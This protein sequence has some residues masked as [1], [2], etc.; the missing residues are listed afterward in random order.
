MDNDYT[1]VNTDKKIN[2]RPSSIAIGAALAVLIISAIVYFIFFNKGN[3]EVTLPEPVLVEEVIVEET[4]VPAIIE[5]E[6][7]IDEEVVAQD[8]QSVIA[9]MD[10]SIIHLSDYTLVEGEDLNSVALKFD[11]DVQTLLSINK[12]RNTSLVVEGYEIKIPNMDGFIYTVRSGDML[13]TISNKFN[14]DIGWYGLR[15]LNDL[16]SDAIFE[17]Q[18]LFIPTYSNDVPLASQTV[19][20]NFAS[21]LKGAITGYY[22]DYYNGEKLSGIVITSTSGEVVSACEKGVVVNV[23]KSEDLGKF[24]VIEH[25]DGYLT[26]YAHLESIFVKKGEEVAKGANISTIGTSDTK[27]TSPSLYFMI[28]QNNIK[29]DP[30]SF[31]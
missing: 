5:E 27:Y 17:G 12:I 3:T 19:N 1:I 29:L 16:D 11:L 25:T 2:I 30:L 9:K 20:L 15:D 8:L 21:P 7:I 23:N 13:S 26:T 22:S 31:F 18:E 6:I 24:I 14:L 28:E 10:D 4:V